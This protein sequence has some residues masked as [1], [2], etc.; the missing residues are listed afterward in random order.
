MMPLII[1]QDFFVSD[2]T[3]KP[4]PQRA[5]LAQIEHRYS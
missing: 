4:P 1:S 5:F 3:F 2:K